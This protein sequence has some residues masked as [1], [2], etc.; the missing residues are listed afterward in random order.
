MISRLWLDNKTVTQ[1]SFAPQSNGASA[2][3]KNEKIKLEA[4]TYEFSASFDYPQLTQLSASEVLNSQSRDLITTETGKTTSLSF[5]SYT[6]KLLAGAW[7]FLT[8]FGRDSMITLLLMQPVLS[9]GQG[10]A[11]EAVIGAVLERI[12]KTDGYVC[13][14]ET[15]GDYATYQHLLLNQRSNKVC[16]TPLE[17]TDAKLTN[18]SQSAAT[19]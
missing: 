19:S 2:S 10:G 16:Q 13:H 1:M 8:Y 6:E 14:E 3:V 5:L 9:E 15:I 12:N 7:R 17:T 11:I 18:P 4:G